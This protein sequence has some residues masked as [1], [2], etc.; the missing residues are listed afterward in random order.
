M[1][2]WLLTSIHPML[3]E[4]PPE[5]GDGEGVFELHFPVSF[6]VRI[7]DLESEL[8]NQMHLHEVWE[9]VLLQ[10]LLLSGNKGK[11]GI[12]WWW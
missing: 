5:A 9:A 4:A 2:G 6:A 7:Q 8:I 3:C 10:P 12:W 11:G 1:V